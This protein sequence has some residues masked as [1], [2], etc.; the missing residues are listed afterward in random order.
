[1]LEITLLQANDESMRAKGLWVA[2]FGLLLREVQIL[3]ND[4]LAAGLGQ[5]SNPQGRIANQRLALVC[6]LVVGVQ[7]DA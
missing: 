5:I 6:R 2:E 7:V 4:R 1:M 3:D